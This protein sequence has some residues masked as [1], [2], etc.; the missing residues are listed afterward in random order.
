MTSPRLI[1]V[2]TASPPHVVPQA[3]ARRFAARAFA[4]EMD[5]DSR[6]M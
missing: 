6:L 2:A 5:R 4:R 3:E 1:S